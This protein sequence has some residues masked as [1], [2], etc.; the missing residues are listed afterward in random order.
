MSHK[1]SKMILLIIV[2]IVIL[3]AFFCYMTF[4]RNKIVLEIDTENITI[5]IG[6]IKKITAQVKNRENVTINWVSDD[7]NIVIVNNGEIT[8]IDVGETIVRAIYQENEE[9]YEK[10]CQVK[11][12][13]GDNSKLLSISFPKGDLVMGVN[14]KFDL[15]NEL[16]KKPDNGYISKIDYTSSNSNISIDENGN[17]LCNSEGFTSIHVKANDTI[18]SNINVYCINEKINPIIIVNPSK[19]SLLND[20]IK[21]NIGEKKKIE[22]T[23]TPSNASKDYLNFSSSDNKVVNVSTDGEIT[24]LSVGKATITVKLLSGESV[25]LIVDVGIKAERIDVE[26]DNISIAMGESID[27]TPTIYPPN[28]NNKTL[29]FMASDNQIISLVPNEDKTKVTIKG[30]VTGTSVVSIKNGDGVEKRVN[31]N[32]TNKK[33]VNPT[34]LSNGDIDS[35]LLGNP[36]NEGYNSCRSISPH[37]TLKINGQTIGQD[38]RVSVHVGDT[39][40]VMVYLPTKCGN[41]IRLTRNTPSGGDNWRN[42]AEQESIPRTDS[43]NPSTYIDGMSVYTWT[44][45]V[46]K[47]GNV[48]LSQTAQFDV[49]APN[50][51]SSN[52]KSM[53]RLGIKIE[54]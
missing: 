14:T 9:K 27:L 42:Y 23:I 36:S 44:I 34:I 49:K 45:T 51:S 26:K 25:T 52:I 37:L 16:I 18:E 15:Y 3:T 22:Y 54:E 53:I 31:I 1:N 33:I 40:N 17:V 46:I 50:G 47:K 2:I 41:I 10:T 4:F 11:V 38:G 5:E 12:I 13:E 30:L 39:F 6:D 35:G 20:N 32:V 24:A 43:E 7:D 28:A 19:I 48:T 29:T 21:M 8:G